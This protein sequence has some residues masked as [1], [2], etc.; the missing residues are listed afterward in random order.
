MNKSYIVEW[1][2]PV[3]LG[4]GIVETTKGGVDILMADKVAKE[5]E[6]KFKPLRYTVHEWRG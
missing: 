1:F 4:R 5:S 2:S 3:T 6:A